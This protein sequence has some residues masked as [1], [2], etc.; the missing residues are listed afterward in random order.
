V[1]ASA[2]GDVLRDIDPQLAPSE[3]VAISDVLWESVAQPRFNTALL[4]VLAACGAVLAAIGTYGIVAFIVSQRV[5][6]IGVRMALG[7]DARSTVTMIVRHALGIVLT[8]AVLGVFAALGATRFLSGQLFDIRPTDPATYGI[9][10]VAAVLVGVL[11]A[12]APARRATRIDPIA[13]LRD[14]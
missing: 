11:S 12:S 3:I 1:V 4:A 8:G 10:V 7:A 9:V 13:S 14:G 5:R 2:F 6:E